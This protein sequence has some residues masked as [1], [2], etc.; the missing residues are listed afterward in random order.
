[1]TIRN[2][3]ANYKKRRR[4]QVNCK[5]YELNRRR[6]LI[7]KE[8]ETNKDL[9]QYERIQNRENMIEEEDINLSRLFE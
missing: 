6:N 3:T 8:A 7:G 5:K 2:M 4:N 1:M 9:K